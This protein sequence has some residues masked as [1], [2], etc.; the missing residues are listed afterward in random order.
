MVDKE[1]ADLTSL[2]EDEN[3]GDLARLAQ[4][5]KAG[6]FYILVGY[7]VVVMRWVDEGILQRWV[8]KSHN[9]GQKRKQLGEAQQ[10]LQPVRLDGASGKRGGPSIDKV[11][12]TGY[13]R[14]IDIRKL[15]VLLLEKKN[16]CLSSLDLKD[17]SRFKE[18]FVVVAYILDGKTHSTTVF[19]LWAALR[20]LVMVKAGSVAGITSEPANL[21]REVLKAIAKQIEEDNEEALG[22]FLISV[23][24]ALAT[25]GVT[26]P[27][28]TL[29]GFIHGK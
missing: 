6:N 20:N 22:D 21:P 4:A 7:C 18:Q 2:A 8:P 26:L 5:F 27:A 11:A 9:R 15:V 13:A 17:P 25:V 10:P 3:L 24:H 1:V 19:R 14:G 29:N 23:I 16:V 12:L 28:S